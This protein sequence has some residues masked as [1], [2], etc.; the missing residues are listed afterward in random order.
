M[1]SI[2]SMN[3]ACWMNSS[4]HASPSSSLDHPKQMHFQTLKFKWLGT[5]NTNRKKR[6]SACGIVDEKLDIDFSDTDWKNKYKKDF[7][8]KFNLPH[9]KDVLDVKQRQT[10][11]SLMQR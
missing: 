2:S 11:F 6:Y 3:N 4:A 1:V 5:H 8:S 10:K 7:E 9:L